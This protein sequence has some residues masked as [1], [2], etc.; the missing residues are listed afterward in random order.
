MAFLTDD[1]YKIQ[2]KDTELTTILGNATRLNAE[3]AAQAE[4][5][6]YLAVRYNVVAVFAAA[7][8]NR[9]NHIVMLMVDI[10]LYHL[11]S[12][13]TPGQVPQI[14]ID[15]YNEA[16]NWLEMVAKGQLLPD[17][18]LAGDADGDGVDDKNVVQ[19]GGRA[20]RDPYF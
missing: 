4:M 13:L 1:D 17:L 8:S 16:K 15:R 12:R 3:N 18:P 11:F 20:K 14:R 5:T 2:V 6:G 10:T 19:W 9:N 7:G